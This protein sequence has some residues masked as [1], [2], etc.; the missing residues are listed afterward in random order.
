MAI[1]ILMPLLGPDVAEGVLTRWLV[2]VGDK[3]KAG[4]IIAE[5][6]T[7][8][9]ALEI[10]AAE[11]GVIEA[12]LVYAGADGVPAGTPVARMRRK[13]EPP[14][15]PAAPA[16]K[17]L[18]SVARFMESHF[19]SKNWN[20]V[21]LLT[22]SEE[23][24]R[25]HPRL[26]RSLGFGD[27]DYGEACLAVLTRMVRTNGANLVII[28]N[29]VA[30]TF[31]G[32][33]LNVSTITA[34]GRPIRFTPS[35]FQVP[36]AAPDPNLIAVMM[37]FGPAFTPVY[38]AIKAAC[39][40]TGRFHAQRADDIWDAT[41]VI[42]DVFSLIFRSH[43]VVCDYT[44]RNPNVFYEAGIAHTLGKIVVPITQ[45]SGDVPFD[46]SHHRYLAYLPNGE[47]LKS[48]EENLGRHLRSL[49]VT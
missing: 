41:T 21:A 4:E 6:E 17:K 24:V 15:Y 5:V 18:L 39:A 25:N 45:S 29:Y 8:K 26:L 9:V 40:S 3:V 30:E 49:A 28:E 27:D 31:D 22:G 35:V 36:T 48:L 37:P 1:E 32:S 47:G 11:E 33:D 44:G 38:G 42:Q 19:S 16:A 7:D 43:A 10:Q 20:E 13:G 23:L 14:T 2:K 46:V 34:S 12:I